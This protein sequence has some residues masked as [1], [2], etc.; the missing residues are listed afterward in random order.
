MSLAVAGGRHLQALLG[1]VGRLVRSPLATLLTLLVIALALALP[2]ALRLFVSNAQAATGNFA[3][4][5]DLSVFLKTDVSLV[6]AQ[7]LAQA[8]HRRIPSRS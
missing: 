2:T 7:Q 8:A 4:A 3:N 6:K 5:I 1:S